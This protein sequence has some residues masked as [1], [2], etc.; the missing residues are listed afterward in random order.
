MA[1]REGRNK[2]TPIVSLMQKSR[3]MLV[4]DVL[5]MMLPT[6]IY[7]M[8]L[9]AQDTDVLIWKTQKSKQVSGQLLSK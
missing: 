5:D 2:L 8:Y 6:M 4:N 9:R 7:L 3:L 1:A